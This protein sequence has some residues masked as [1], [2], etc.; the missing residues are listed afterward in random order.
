MNE[1]KI[2]NLLREYRLLR[3]MTQAQ[4]AERLGYESSQFVSLLERNESK[5][6][7]K[8]LGQLIV[9]LEIPESEILPAIFKSHEL[10]LQSQI[11]LGKQIAEAGNVGN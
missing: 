7:L 11:N 9:I 1:L 2:G 10:A 8:T 5:C 4:L 6:P 3:E